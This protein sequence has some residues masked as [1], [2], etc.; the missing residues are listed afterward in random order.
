MPIKLW[1]RSGVIA[2]L[3]LAAV[4]LGDRTQ[5]QSDWEN[6][7]S[8]YGWC[9]G[10]TTEIDTAFGAV[11]AELS[12]GATWI[13]PV[14]VARVR[15]LL[16]DDWSFNGSVGVGDF[17]VGDASDLSWQIYARV[18]HDFNETWA[19]PGG[20]RYLAFDTDIDRRDIRLEHYGPRFG[21]TAR[22]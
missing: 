9:I 6:D 15:S 12:L 14:M 3:A 8:I 10:T 22:I 20:Y 19:M 1:S 7:L 5:A 18:D 13:D 16:S 21:V 17:E 11:D 2:G 4:A